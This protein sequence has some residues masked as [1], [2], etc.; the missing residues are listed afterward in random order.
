MKPRSAVKSDLFAAESRAPKID[1]LGD[2]LVKISEVVDFAA[3]SSEVDRV[4]PRVVSTKG[5]R[6]PFPTET[7]VRILVL[8][9]LHN[10]L[11]EQVEFQLLDRLSFPRFCGL[12]MA[13][14][15]PDRT[16]V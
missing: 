3:L 11:D 10:L 14:N 2:P 5:G 8:K 4:A 7:M 13:T 1:S 12:T 15:I 6:P 9:R 16:T